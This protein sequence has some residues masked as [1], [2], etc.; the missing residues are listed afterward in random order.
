MLF[1]LSGR[2]VADGEDLTGN[3]DSDGHINFSVAKFGVCHKSE[4]VNPTT[5]ETIGISGITDKYRE[6]DSVSL[7]R[8]TDSYNSTMLVGL[9][10]THNFSVKFDKVNWPTLADGPSYIA[11]QNP[12]SFPPTGVNI[13]SEKAGELPGVCFSWEL[14]QGSTSLVDIEYKGVQWQKIQQ[15]EPQMTI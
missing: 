10:S 14:S 7:R 11:R 5:S 15:Q 6:N 13:K 9:L 4:K 8:K 3:Y 1:C 12:I 2:Y